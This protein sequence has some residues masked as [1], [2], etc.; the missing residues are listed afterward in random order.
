MECLQNTGF[1][2]Q[3]DVDQGNSLFLA[4]LAQINDVP[5]WYSAKYLRREMIIYFCQHV[6]VLEVPKK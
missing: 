1:Y 3:M 2:F 6:E 4:V 5:K